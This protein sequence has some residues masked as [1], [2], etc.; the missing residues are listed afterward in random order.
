MRGDTGDVYRRM[1]QGESTR[2]YTKVLAENRLQEGYT[3]RECMTLEKGMTRWQILSRIINDD[4]PPAQYK[5]YVLILS[6]R[7][8]YT[9]VDIR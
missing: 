2:R 6:H 3:I 9:V 7:F 1:S 5:L 8:Y 4:S